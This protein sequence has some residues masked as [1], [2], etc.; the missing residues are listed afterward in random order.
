M[1]DGHK[2]GGAL[3]SLSNASLIQILQHHEGDDKLTQ[4]KRKLRGARSKA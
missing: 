1:N 3:Q 4:M 2:V